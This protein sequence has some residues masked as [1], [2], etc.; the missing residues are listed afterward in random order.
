M[1]FLVNAASTYLGRPLPNMCVLYGAV[2]VKKKIKLADTRGIE[3]KENCSC[4]DNLVF[5]TEKCAYLHARFAPYVFIWN[6]SRF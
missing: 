3:T 5:L 4:T 2:V 6:I 1:S